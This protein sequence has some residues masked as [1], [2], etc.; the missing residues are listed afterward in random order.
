MGRNAGYLGNPNLKPEGQTVNFTKE[1][2]EEYIKCA[3]DPVYFIQK[4]IKVVSLDKGLVPF[5]LFDYQ[6]DMINKIHDNRFI[7]AKLPRQSGKTTTVTSYLLH[8]ILF[9]QSMNVAILANKQSTAK[10]IL[11]RLKLAYEYLPTWL[12][13]GIKEW[14]KYSIALE[15]GSRV[16][17]AATSSSAIRGGSYNFL[18]LDEY[19]HVP[20]NV[21]EEFFSSVYPTITSG[22]TT[23]VAMISTPKGLNMFYHFWKGAQSKQNEYIP[24]EVTW[25][26]VPKYP[27]G[28]L[29]D[30]EWK[31]ETIRNSS[32]RQFQEEFICD[33][34]GSSNTLIS[35]EKLNNLTWVK[36]MSKTNDGL[37]IFADP[38]KET[39]TTP[40]HTY[41]IVVDVARG[42]GKDYSALTV[43]DITQ[44]PYKIVAKYRN[45]IISPLLFPSIIRSLGKRY[46]DAYVMV[47]LNDIGSQ[48]ADILHTDLEYENLIKSNMRGR[49]GQIITEGFGSN[50]SQQLGIRTSQVV[51]KL[52]CSVLKNLIENDKLIIE[53]AEII[54]ELTTFISTNASFSADRGYNDDMVMTLVLFAWSTRQ[55]FFKNLTNTDVRLEMYEQDIKKI[56]DELLPF[57]YILDGVNDDSIEIEEN[58]NSEDNWLIIDKKT[59]NDNWI[60]LYK[61]NNF[62]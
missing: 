31:Q 50:K 46:N 58:W 5:H 15:N 38:V 10:D 60:D 43:I 62:F 57:G 25:N 20:T 2:I 28:P 21:A 4:Y 40:L 34:I 6:E 39:E 7:I 37:T 26:Q 19:A 53:D 44:M 18:V 24:I 8:Y 11:A 30:E 1:Q 47:E 9:N 45:N 16:I 12:Q 27:G 29:R 41:F 33:F 13:Q 23:K 61:Q 54:E 22:Q 56:E 3:K 14:N 42:Q 49:K 52:G 36:P 55:E 17:A 59:Q 35:S 48:V 32:E 51:K